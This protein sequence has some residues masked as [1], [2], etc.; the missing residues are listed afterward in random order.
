MVDTNSTKRESVAFRQDNA[1]ARQSIISCPCRLSAHDAAPTIFGRRAEAVV[2]PS[3]RTPCPSVL[4]PC[5]MVELSA[6]E[7]EHLI[8]VDDRIDTQDVVLARCMAERIIEIGPSDTLLNMAKRTIALKYKTHDIANSMQ[9][10]FLSY[11]KDAKAIYFEEDPVEEDVAVPVPDAAVAGPPSSPAIVTSTPPKAGGALPVTD[12][13]IAATEI[14]KILVS[15]SLK[16]AVD[17]VAS[18]SSIKALAGG[19]ST[20]QNEIIGDLG[21]EFGPLP[22]GAEDLPLEDLSN[23][24]QASFE[25]RLGKQSMSLIGKLVSSK[26][27]G[28][29]NLAAVRKYLQDR[30][31]FAAGRQDSVLLLAIIH[32]PGGRISGEAEAQLFLDGLVQTHAAASGLSLTATQDDAR[33]TSAANVSVDLAMLDHLRQD[34]LNFDKKI[35][36]LYAKKLKIDL[37]TKSISTTEVQNSVQ[38]ELD[39]LT[40]ELGEAYATGIKPRFTPLKARIY[41]SYWNWAQQD[42]LKLVHDVVNGLELSQ[43]ELNNQVNRLA[44]RSNQRLLKSVRYH[45]GKLSKP[46]NGMEKTSLTATTAV[47]VLIEDIQTALN[48]PPVFR[49]A[50]GVFSPRTI[51]DLLGNV[52]YVEVPKEGQVRNKGLQ[53]T[54]PSLAKQFPPRRPSV[55]TRSNF[56]QCEEPLKDMCRNCVRF[57][58]ISLLQIRTKSNNNWGYNQSL[59]ETYLRH[60]DHAASCGVSFSGKTVLVTGAGFGSIGAKLVQGLLSGGAQVVVTSSSY[61]SKVTK[62][63]QDMYAYY[64]TKCSRLVV[65]PFNQGSRQDTENLVNYI[66]DEK[67][68]LGWDLDHIIPFAAI[69]ENGREIDNLDSRSELAHRVMLTNTLRLLGAVKKQ[70]NERKIRTRPAQVILP[71]SPNHGTFGNDGLYSESKLGLEA[72]FN[73]WHSEAWSDYLS[74]CGA[75]IGWTRGTGLMSGN[76]IIA[77]GIEDLGVKTFSQDEMA[78]A[79]LGLMASPLFSACQIEPLFAD[80]SG[81]MDAVHNL[82]EVTSRLRATITETSNIRRAIAEEDSIDRKIE[83]HNIHL[84]D[85][86]SHLLSRR[87]NINIEFP[88]L[89]DYKEVERINEHLLGMV[90]LE[91][92]VVITGFSELGPYGNSR[93]RWEMEAFGKF[94]V[95]GCIQMAWMMGLI[96]NSGPLLNGKQ[97][98]G[99]V[100]IKS[101]EAISD[102]DIKKKYEA[103]ILAHTGIRVVEPRPAD[104]SNPWRKQFLHEVIIQHDLEIFEASKETAL[105]FLRE[106]GDKVNIAEIPETGEYTIQIRKGAVLMIPKALEFNHAVGGQI[107]TGWN[108]RV[109]G[110]SEDIISQVDQASLYAL[111]CT[112]EAFLSAGITD[113]YELYKY[114]HVSELGNCVGSGLGG[115]AS[116]QKMFKQRFMDKPVQK[117]I[118]AETFINTIGAWINMLLLSSSGP[119]STPVGACATAIESLDVGYGLIVNGKAK[120]CLVGGLDDMTQ[121]ISYEF[122]NMKATI[123]ATN[124]MAHGRDPKEMSRPTA[125]TRNGFVESEGCGLQLLTTAKLAIEMGLPIYGIVALTQTAMDKIGRS[126]PAPG[127]G[128]LTTVKEAPTSYPSPM[129]DIKYRKRNLDLRFSQIEEARETDLLYLEDETSV[130]KSEN[131]A[132]IDVQEYTK[133]RKINIEAEAQRQWKESLKSYGNQFWHGDSRISPLRGALAVWGLTIDDLGVAS[134]HGTST[135]LSEKNESEVIHRQLTHLGRT[136]GN[137]I[138]CVFQKHLTGHPKG[139]AGAWMINGCLQILSSGL[140]PGNRNADNIDASLSSFSHLTFPNK[141]IQTSGIKAFSVTSFGFGQKGGQAIGVHPDYLFATLDEATYLEYKHKREERRLK[142]DRFFQNA[143]LRNS[144]FVAKERPPYEEDEDRGLQFIMDPTTRV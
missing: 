129:L 73:K 141:N 86:S 111:V 75:S 13:A 132:G 7:C 123:N 85:R 17:Q 15:H 110:I 134:F 57:H 35:L 29:F 20:L 122:A 89:L 10:E 82:K 138:L 61:S 135:K 40:D 21:N 114:I 102:L 30:W 60:L 69:S 46:S 59:T 52:R 28:G 107:P 62:D 87:A 88:P 16:K 143:M 78:F 12:K 84:S 113:T 106:H 1:V 14:L 26:M 125:T 98:P 51:I 49:L 2:H 90:D 100:D 38:A 6:L 112:V 66:Y 109:Y 44:N 93:T 91:S 142:A 31:G 80:L 67:A 18:S 27:P 139:A 99:W 74:I 116:L 117:D 120:A 124:D 43:D 95:E 54:R 79:I 33:K 144:L 130:L 8:D 55:V 96:K 11:K 64:G 25:G 108:P 56:C 4:F 97:C 53:L 50:S 32:Q 72:L 58:E 9:R 45:A 48:S 77:E 140:V 24:L 127:K 83:E 76:D 115:V 36:D 136:P 81:G 103:H 70:K 68:G 126:V 105:D 63:Y 131:H 22:E 5:E 3:G 92:V 137:D 121:D 37:Q 65:V 133:E 71:L 39:H 118:L 23:A 41:D 47:R 128:I 34:E 42:L 104:G 94:S 101:G 119:T 19:R